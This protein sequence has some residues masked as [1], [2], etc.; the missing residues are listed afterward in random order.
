MSLD[1][2]ISSTHYIDLS[3]IQI[4][5]KSINIQMKKQNENKNLVGSTH[6]SQNHQ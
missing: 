3:F 4:E 6:Q 5:G 1:T 2:C